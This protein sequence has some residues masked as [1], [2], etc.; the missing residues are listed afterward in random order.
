MGLNTGILSVEDLTNFGSIEVI[1]RKMI[2]NNTMCCLN[3]AQAVI[4][5]TLFYRYLIHIIG[6][7]DMKDSLNTGFRGGVAPRA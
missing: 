6:E 4:N 2:Y 1:Q 7:P 3:S 5:C